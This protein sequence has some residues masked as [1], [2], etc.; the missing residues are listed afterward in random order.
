MK[1]KHAHLYTCITAVLVVTVIVCNNYLVEFYE[2]N[3]KM[4]MK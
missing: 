1:K 2:K 4:K 3:E